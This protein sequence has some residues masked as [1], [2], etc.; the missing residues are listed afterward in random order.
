MPHHQP[1]QIIGF[2]S[3][4][5][6]TGLKV[7]NGETDLNPSTNS[8]DWLGQGVYFWEQN[9]TRALEYA[10]ESSQKKQFNKVP[11]KTPFVLGAIIE[12]GNCLNLIEHASISIL[13][14]AYVGLEAYCKEAG[15][16]MP[17]NKGDVRRL[18]CAVVR[19]VHETRKRKGEKAYD[20]IR[21]AFSEGDLL[22]QDSNFSTR[23]HIQVCVLNSDLIR[24]YFAS[25][26]T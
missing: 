15:R 1:F 5:K 17:E 23:L 20:T 4:D 7:L 21:C 22:Y 3:C 2:H 16:N 13:K 8:W 9:P 6:E 10:I 12:L 18:D 24:G 14:E 25:T 11:I 19:Y 26:H